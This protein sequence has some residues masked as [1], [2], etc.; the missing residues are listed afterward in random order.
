[1]VEAQGVKD[2]TKDNY[3]CNKDCC[4][5]TNNNHILSIIIM[6]E[7]VE[8]WSQFTHITFLQ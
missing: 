4:I 7:F 1:M 8:Y 3:F 2:Y 6:Q 5:D